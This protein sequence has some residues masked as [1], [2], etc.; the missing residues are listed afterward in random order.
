MFR[1]GVKRAMSVAERVRAIRETH[2][3]SIRDAEQRTGISRGTLHRMELGYA[4]RDLRATVERFAAAY[5][6]SVDELLAGQTPRGILEWRIRRLDRRERLRLVMIGLQGRVYLALEFLQ[7]QF[8]SQLDLQRLS[9]ASSLPRVE[10]ETAIRNWRLS[11]PD[12]KTAEHIAAGIHAGFGISLDWM[13]T[14]YFADEMGL[15]VPVRCRIPVVAVNAQ[16]ARP[17]MRT[18]AAKV[19]EVVS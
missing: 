1:Q 11:E 6:I 8:S 18:S 13:L 19:M 2:G 7:D 17:V 3:D 15:T 16:C 12:R 5:G 14:G 9:I 10:V 4:P